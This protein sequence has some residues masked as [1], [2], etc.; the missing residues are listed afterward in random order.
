MLTGWIIVQ[1][2]DRATF[3]QTGIGH[4]IIEEFGPEESR[5]VV[6]QQR[7]AWRANCPGLAFAAAAVYDWPNEPR[8]VRIFIG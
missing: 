8:P 2:N 3:G 4:F 7:D 5:E 6:K 1:V